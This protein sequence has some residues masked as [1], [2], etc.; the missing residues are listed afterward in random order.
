MD[1]FDLKKSLRKFHPLKRENDND[2]DNEN[3]DD[4]II[5]DDFGTPIPKYIYDDAGTKIRLREKSPTL[6]IDEYDQEEQAEIDME[7]RVG[8]EMT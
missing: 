7:N 5:Y 6:P 3:E 4:D 1:N 8:D 2:V